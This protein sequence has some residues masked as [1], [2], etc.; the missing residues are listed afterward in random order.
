MVQGCVCDRAISIDN[1]YQDFNG[2][3]TREDFYPDYYQISL[4]F[5]DSYNSKT[6]VYQNET[7]IHNQTETDRFYRCSLLNVYGIIVLFISNNVIYRGPYA[8]AVTDFKGYRCD[9]ALCP[10]GDDPRTVYGK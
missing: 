6:G 1:Q 3:D 7:V 9:L 8:L 4:Y 2:N 10:K 5:N